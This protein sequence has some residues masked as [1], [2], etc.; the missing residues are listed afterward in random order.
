M[1]PDGQV[2]EGNEREPVDPTFEGKL[3][4][5][6]RRGSK[7]IEKENSGAG[8]SILGHVVGIL[9]LALGV[10]Y[11]LLG[12]ETSWDG[13]GDQSFV[14]DGFH[15]IVQLYLGSQDLLVQL[16]L[17]S[18]DL[19]VQF[20]IGG[21][22]LILLSLQYTIDHFILVGSALGG[23]IFLMGSGD[24][25]AGFDRL[26]QLYFQAVELIIQLYSTGFDLV[27][28]FYI[29]GIDLVNQLFFGAIEITVWSVCALPGQLL[30][31]LF[32][33]KTTH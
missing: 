8:T 32:E 16:L 22:D 28:Q 33:D 17:G 29:N 2:L 19:L 7:I 18:Q 3:D 25:W 15:L 4:P 10:G 6:G 21:F 31:R 20:F 14:L 5:P 26:V 30:A 27:W 23:T 13:G 1:D 24:F 12:Q 11:L 9:V